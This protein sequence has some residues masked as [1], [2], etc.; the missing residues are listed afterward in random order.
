MSQRKR[1]KRGISTRPAERSP[2]IARTRP[3]H[4]SSN[5]T[6]P[7]FVPVVMCLN[8]RQTSSFSCCLH[9]CL[10]K[11]INCR[12]LYFVSCSLKCK[13]YPHWFFRRYKS[14]FGI[15][16]CFVSQNLKGLQKHSLSTS[17]LK[18]FSPFSDTSIVFLVLHES[19][20]QRK[21]R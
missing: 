18:S 13:S 20:L 4:R 19:V 16:I 12:S 10:S 11:K 5:R 17:F 15:L 9:R 1:E 8:G 2:L 7:I 3:P 14:Y 21:P 6:S